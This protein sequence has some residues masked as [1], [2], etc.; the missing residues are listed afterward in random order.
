MGCQK[1]LIS[2]PSK[3]NLCESQSKRVL[4]LACSNA[5]Y[6]IMSVFFISWAAF[7][8]IAIYASLKI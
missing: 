2:S 7:R 8:L 1:K 4:K 6:S 3:F 5:W